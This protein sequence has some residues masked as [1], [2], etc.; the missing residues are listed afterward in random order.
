MKGRSGPLALL[1]LVLDAAALTVSPTIAPL[2]RCSRVSLP[3]SMGGSIPDDEKAPPAAVPEPVGLDVEAAMAEAEALEAAVAAAEAKLAAAQARAAVTAARARAAASAA[4]AKA[5]AKARPVP[6]QP[7]VI[8]PD[9]PLVA[10]PDQPLVAVPDGVEEGALAT[11]GGGVPELQWLDAAAERA[12]ADG[13]RTV[14]EC[15]GTGDVLVSLGG[16][17]SD[18]E[19]EELLQAG[20]AACDVQRQ[21]TGREPPPGG[22]D[23]FSVSDPLAFDSDVVLACE[24]LLLR[25]LDRVDEQLSSVYDA[26]FAPSEGWL[27]RQPLTAAGQPPTVSPPEHLQDAC[28]SL[29]D[30]YMAGEL[31]WSEGEPA[32]NVY[33]SGGFPTPALPPTLTPAPAPAPTPTLARRRLRRPQG[34]HGTHLHPAAHVPHARLLGGRHGLLER[35]GRGGRRRPRGGRHARRQQGQRQARRA[36]H[37]HLAPAARHGHPLRGRRD[38]CGD[39]RR[40]GHARRARGE[41]QHAHRRLERRARQ[42]AARLLGLERAA[43]VLF[44]RRLHMRNAPA[45]TKYVL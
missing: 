4:K 34:P 39:A 7:L 45:G 40:G 31:E 20:L 16:V 13:T 21:R 35:R 19:L 12:V 18:A 25:V 8:V 1:V 14:G 22:K 24:E 43:R 15:I 32:I 6:D 29:R 2:Y 9:Q 33:T 36:A 11:T 37:G 28:P 5:K 27:E 10:V 44:L 3:V 41:L 26:L 17:A 23:R 30:L 42:R 38:P